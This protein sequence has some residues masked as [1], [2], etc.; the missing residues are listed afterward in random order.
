ML[1][2]EVVSN[3]SVYIMNSE[4]WRVQSR[5]FEKALGLQPKNMGCRAVFFIS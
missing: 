1:R 3:M 2:Q 5:I 4:R